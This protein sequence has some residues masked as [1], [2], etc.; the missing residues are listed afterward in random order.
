MPHSS[1]GANG[2]GPRAAPADNR[3]HEGGSGCFGISEPLQSGKYKVSAPS[4]VSA[5]CIDL[6][7]SRLIIGRMS[8]GVA[9]SASQSRCSPGNIR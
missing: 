6:G 2:I 3:A 1:G 7:L 4:S 8:V 9:V 5:N